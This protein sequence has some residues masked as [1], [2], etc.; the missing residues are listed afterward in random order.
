MVLKTCLIITGMENRKLTD[1]STRLAGI[2]D[3]I[4]ED[5]SDVIATYRTEMPPESQTD[6]YL[7]S[8][9]SQ[10]RLLQKRME[11]MEPVNMLALEAYEETNNR[12]QE[13]SD[14]L[15]TLEAESMEL[16]LRIENFTTL[17]FQAFSEAFDAVNA[18]F[19]NIFAE[20]SD[21]D[22]FLQLENAEDPFAGGLNLVYQTTATLASGDSD[23]RRRRAS[24]GSVISIDR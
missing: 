18:N 19:Q 9:Q 4:S 22:G 12:L 23:R 21:G 3:S 11:G 24:F 14:K 1:I 13:L 16:L 20:L 7:A 17:R 6:E 2:G 5:K 8:L 10:I 15:G